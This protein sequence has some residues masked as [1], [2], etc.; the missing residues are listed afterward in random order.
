M[1]WASVAFVWVVARRGRVEVCND[2]GEGACK[3]AVGIGYIFKKD[4]GASVCEVLELQTE[5]GS[6]SGC[7]LLQG[8]AFASLFFPGMV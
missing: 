4:F 8:T 3:G 6:W 2:V 7:S 5:L 1:D